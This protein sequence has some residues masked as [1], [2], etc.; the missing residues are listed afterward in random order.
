MHHNKVHTGFRFYQTAE[1]F[2]LEVTETSVPNTK[3]KFMVIER[4]APFN[5]SVKGSVDVELDSGI[6]CAGIYGLFELASGHLAL[7]LVT[8]F[9]RV[10]QIAD[11]SVYQIEHT[12]TFYTD[13]SNKSSVSTDDAIYRNLL[14]SNLSAAKENLYFSYGFPNITTNMQDSYKRSQSLDVHN[15]TLL[16]HA[17]ER[18]CWNFAQLSRFLDSGADCGSWLLPIMHGFVGI[19]DVKISD[20]DATFALISRRSRHRVGTRFNKRGID[21]NGYVANHVETEQILTTGDQLASFVQTRG[22]IPIY[23]QQP[24]TMKYTPKCNIIDKDDAEKHQSAYTKHLDDQIERY[25]NQ[26]LVN[27]VD[28]KKDQLMLSE[29]F[30]AC[31]NK[32]Q[33]NG[34]N[35]VQYI[36]WD[37]HA[38]CKGMKYGKIEE[39]L[40]PMIQENVESGK[41]CIQTVA[42]QEIIKM[43]QEQDHVIRTNCM[44]C[45]DRTNVVQSVFDRKMVADQMKVLFGETPIDWNDDFEVV[46][47]NVWA[48][49]AD[50]CSIQYSGTPALK[51]DFTRTGKRTIAGALQDG[52]N[53]LMRYFLNNYYDG[54]RQDS[55]DYVAGSVTPAD[56]KEPF[57]GVGRYQG[58]AP[59]TVVFALYA[60]VFVLLMVVTHFAVPKDFPVYA[61]ALAWAVITYLAG[62]IAIIPNGRKIVDKPALVVE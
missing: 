28:K 4:N 51:T 59:M 36:H 1:A 61:T 54:F 53:S 8:E 15:S 7:V 13:S 2:V 42:N 22:S 58:M 25:G 48:D 40:W 37:F 50:A 9:S 12:A 16:D 29:F 26:S 19:A 17:E 44:D 3:D 14:S 6:A 31:H 20:H 38:C 47:R 41:Y 18:F 49:N 62:Q 34:N 30:E 32:Y 35:Q 60:L 5:I 23:W 39:D 46:Y 57:V 24:V 33:P 10:G 27:L 56:V 11:G 52:K 43:T 45:L 55:L 21:A